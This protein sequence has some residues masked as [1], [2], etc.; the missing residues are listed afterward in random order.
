MQRL[1]HG[2]NLTE[3]F[4]DNTDVSDYNPSWADAAGALIS[5]SFDL[6]RFVVGLFNGNVIP[7]KQ[8]EELTSIVSAETGKPVTNIREK[9]GY[10]LGM[11]YTYKD[12]IGPVWYKNGETF[13]YNSLFMWLPC[14]ELAIGIT[15]NNATDDNGIVGLHSGVLNTLLISQEFADA[16][17]HH[18]HNP[19]S[20]SYCN[21]TGIQLLQ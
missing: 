4:S 21:K 9:D 17:H 8:F 13:G 20:P 15:K 6:T 7:Q 10:G 2:Y 19:E 12:G 14:L 11:D 18:I 16:Y 5:N 3:I 1:A